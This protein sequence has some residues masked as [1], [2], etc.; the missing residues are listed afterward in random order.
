MMEEEENFKVEIIDEQFWE[1]V[2]A[3]YDDYVSN[4][5]LGE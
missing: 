1:E 2:D 3:A 5:L 4:Q